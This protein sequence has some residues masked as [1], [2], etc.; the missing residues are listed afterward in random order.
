MSLGVTRPTYICAYKGL[1]RDR[2]L[3]SIETEV[4]LAQR[5]SQHTQVGLHSICHQVSMLAKPLSLCQ[6]NLHSICHQVSL[7]LHTYALIGVQ[8]AYAQSYTYVVVIYR[9]LVSIRACRGLVSIR[10][11]IYV[12]SSC[13]QG[14]S[15]HT[16]LQGFSSHTRGRIRMQQLYICVVYAY[17]RRIRS[18]V[19]LVSI[20]TEVQVQFA[21]RQRFRFSSHRDS[22]LGLVQGTG[23]ERIE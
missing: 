1:V 9:G 13:T 5:F 11:V 3:A 2:G 7:G 22:G 23:R 6:L 14:F 8:L 19:G 18:L 4:Q 17:I 15:Q 16:R 20:E 10:V 12:C 21:Q